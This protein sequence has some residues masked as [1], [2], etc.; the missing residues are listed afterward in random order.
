MTRNPGVPAAGDGHPG[1]GEPEDELVRQEL[2]QAQSKKRTGVKRLTGAIVTAGVIVV[3]F[4]F[5]LPTIANY[6]DVWTIIQRVPW[7]WMVALAVAV[8]LDVLTYAPPWMAALPGLG[9]VHSLRVTQ[10]STALSMV[11]PGGAAVG[12]ATSFAMLKNWGLEGRPVGLAALVTSAWNQLAIFGFPVLAVAALAAEGARNRTLEWV[13]LVGIVVFSIVVAGFA[14]G[15]RSARLAHGIGNRVAAGATSLRRLLGSG[16]VGWDGDGFVRFREEAVG[17]LRRRW[18]ALTLATLANHLTV[19]VLTLFSLRA[20]GIT[21]GEV[22]IVEAFAAW[23]VARVLGSI[24][25]TPGGVGIV[26]LGLTGVLVGFGAS[27]TQAVAA[28]LLCRFL[29][30]VPTLLLGLLAAS[31]WRFR[32][33]KVA[34]RAMP[35]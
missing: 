29:Q 24:P 9:Y 23:S 16:P 1:V 26:E 25:I 28:T 3:V 12:M 19:F 8:I 30:T 6:A 32:K 4:L 2:E 5:V 11:A 17:L 10:A 18:V 13:A 14:T 35:E 33:P 7:P 31:T 15:L 21:P 27:S 34:A 22:S 20:V